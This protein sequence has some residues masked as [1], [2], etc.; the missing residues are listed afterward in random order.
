M[1]LPENGDPGL[2]PERA[3]SET[4][5][6]SCSTHGDF[7]ADLYNAGLDL[8]DMLQEPGASEATVA[9]RMAAE[10]DDS[11]L[12]RMWESGQASTSLLV[13]MTGASQRRLRSTPLP[14]T[15]PMPTWN[16]WAGTSI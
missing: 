5:R 14:T 8:A 10:P 9:D 15:P 16:L 2:T 6:R 7:Y 12:V 3:A 13:H 4:L 11:L 1:T